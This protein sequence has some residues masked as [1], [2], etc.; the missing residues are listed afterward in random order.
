M[1]ENGNIT[2]TSPGFMGWENEDFRLHSASVCK[3]KGTGV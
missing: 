2:G 3:N 1:T